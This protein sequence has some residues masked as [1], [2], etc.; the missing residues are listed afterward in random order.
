MPNSEMVPESF[1]QHL[2][3][4]LKGFTDLEPQVQR[5][6]AYLVWNYG[7]WQR[8]HKGVPGHMTISYQELQHRFGRDGFKRANSAVPSALRPQRKPQSL[9]LRKHIRREPRA[10]PP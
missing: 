6:L 5:D 1:L 9:P 7:N 2:A 3:E 4:R 8:E 10:R